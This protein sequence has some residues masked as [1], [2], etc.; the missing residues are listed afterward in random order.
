MEKITLSEIEPAVFSDESE[1]RALADHLQ[2]TEMALN[3]YRIEPG[4]G[5]P[6]GLHAHLDQEEVFI[7]REGTLTFETMQGNITVEE[8]EAIR[9][10]PGEF[11]SGRNETD[12]DLV[13]LAIGAPRE[14]SDVRIPVE[15]PACGFETLRLDFSG[16]R[17]T[18]D[19]PDCPAHHTPRDCPECGHDDLRLSHDEQTGTVVICQ[20][21][22][23]DFERPPLE[24]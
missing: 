6:G 2:T 9:F 18:F 5:L 19:C 1:R 22:G 4:E 23:T 7:V 24:E 12:S 15:C 11:Q 14:T 21:C 17:L 13:V 8:S 20:G 3:H 10:A 16:E